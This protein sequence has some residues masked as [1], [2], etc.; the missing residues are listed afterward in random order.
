[1]SS[2]PE[3][4]E[5]KSERST[6]PA[7]SDRSV[8]RS[9]P[10][11]QLTDKPPRLSFSISA[12]IGSSNHDSRSFSS[13]PMATAMAN[14]PTAM[15]MNAIKHDNENKLG[16]DGD[17]AMIDDDVDEGSDIDVES[18][19]GEERESRTPHSD[20]GH[21]PL[22]LQ[23]GANGTVIRVP[24]QRPPTSEGSPFPSGASFPWAAANPALIKDHRLQAAAAAAFSALTAPLPP[25][26]IGHP[27]QNRTPP[28][29]KK[30]R[31]SFTRMQI[32]ELEKRF[33]KQKYL[34]SAERAQLAKQLKMTDAQVKTWFQN[35][36]TKWRRQT[37]EERE[38][39]R[40]AANRLMMSLQAEVVQK[41]M[42]FA[43]QQVA[44]DPRDQLQCLS[45]ASLHA[46]QS[47]QPWAAEAAAL[48][49]AQ[50]AAALQAAAAG[51][52]NAP[53]GSAGGPPAPHFLTTPLC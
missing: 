22:P 6:S 4:V 32:C 34:A 30:P 5:A 13:L 1:M 31:T 29:R 11:L 47:L 27:Y 45:S 26:R 23:L 24:A 9:S 40:Q 39:E 8:Q 14:T 51:A 15:L 48:N 7:E 46:L 49:A 25:R 35:R 33:H 38:A 17:S 3:P 43:A 19:S 37:A 20:A 18:E 2:T 16:I 12:L 10:M 52:P 28:K 21:S 44:S 42:Q 50:Q 36:R 53:P 41:S